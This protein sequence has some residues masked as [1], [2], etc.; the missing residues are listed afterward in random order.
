MNMIGDPKTER[1]VCTLSV[2]TQTIKKSEGG[3]DTEYKSKTDK[4][5]H[6]TTHNYVYAIPSGS[7]FMGFT[8]VGREKMPGNAAEVYEKD[9]SGYT[10]TVTN[11]GSFEIRQ[12]YD[13]NEQ[14]KVTFKDANGKAVSNITK[15]QWEMDLSSLENGGHLY[16]DRYAIFTKTGSF[17]L[18]VIAEDP[19]AYAPR[20][21]PPNAC[22]CPN[23]RCIA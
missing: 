22:L 3:L 4:R 12:K 11:N 9:R 23:S 14:L 15:Y 16:D 19:A 20:R 13:L 18:A 8:K 6:W 21:S 2:Q 10:V 17:R 7:A 1:P 5:K